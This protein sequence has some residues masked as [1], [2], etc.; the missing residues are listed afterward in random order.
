MVKRISR[1]LG[2]YIH[3]EDDIRKMVK[4]I[5]NSTEIFTN[6]RRSTWEIL[7]QLATHV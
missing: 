2:R 6:Y 3:N 5:R 4:F 1:Y 7:M